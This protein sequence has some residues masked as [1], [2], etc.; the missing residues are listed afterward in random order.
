MKGFNAIAGRQHR[1]AS[2]SQGR[3]V[4]GSERSIILDYED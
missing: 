1:I 4:E 3:S 2:H